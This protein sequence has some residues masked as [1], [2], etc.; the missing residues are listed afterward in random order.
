MGIRGPDNL[1]DGI[2]R[3]HLLAAMADF[4]R[5]VEHDF[6]DS[7]T[8]DVLHDA[9]R[10]PPKVVVG[11]AAGH[12]LGKP[13][14][15][16]DFRAGLGTKCFRVLEAGGFK[17]LGKAKA[18]PFPEELVDEPFYEG[19]AATVQVNRF[20][21]D[22]KAR[23]AC[24]RHY[25]A[26]CQACGFDFAKRYGAL[27]EGF[28]H[29]HHIVPLSEVR[30]SYVVD[31]VKDLRPICPNCHAMLHRQRPSLSIEDLKGM[32]RQRHRCEG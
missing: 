27:G 1:P 7:T 13:L 18:G 29:V 24:I 32:L 10:Y 14:G 16:R 25:G 21:R 3:E 17:I 12:L 26:R 9:R 20:E 2:K 8:Y 19:A 31:P 30:S 11:L 23:K 6:R 15:P 5:G 28:I 4:D 22:P